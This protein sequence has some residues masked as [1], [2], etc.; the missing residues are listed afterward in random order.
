MPLH[1]K[2][3]N[4]YEQKGFSCLPSSRPTALAPRKTLKSFTVDPARLPP[5]LNENLSQSRLT[6]QRLSI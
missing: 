5:L 3:T 1:T 4:N 2:L 6:Q